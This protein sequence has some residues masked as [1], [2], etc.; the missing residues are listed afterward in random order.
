MRGRA[1]FWNGEAARGDDQDR[2]AKLGGVGSHCKLGGVLNFPDSGVEKKLGACIAALGFEHVGDV[3]RGTVAEKL[4]ESFLVVRDAMFF[5][6]RDEVRRGIAGERGFCKVF[7]RANEIFRAAVDVR[8][9][10]T[11][12]A[13]DENLLADAVGPLKEGDPASAFA[14][15]RRAEESRGAGAENYCV[16]FVRQWSQTI[17]TSLVVANC[18]CVRSSG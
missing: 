12:A 8:E 13:G 11:S 17:L 2:S 3:L 16:K 9:V 4:P 6:Q 14:G 15:F 5:D 1:D 18:R 7:I 10:A